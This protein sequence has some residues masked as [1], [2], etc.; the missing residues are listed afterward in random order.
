MRIR[1]HWGT[2]VALVYS[3]FALG[4]LGFVAFAMG[5][6]PTLVSPQYYG[7][8]LAHDQRMAAAANARTLGPAPDVRL[9]TDGTEMVLQLP[10]SHAASARGTLT[11]Y[12]AS[13]AGADRVVAL[14]LAPDG[15]QRVSLDGLAGGRWRVQV[16][17]TVDG[18]PYYYERPFDKPTSADADQGRPVVASPNG[19]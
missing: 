17:W 3:A 1:L 2:G 6:P 14:S 8:A 12:R 13:D 4:T 9:T 10:A 11:L 5:R 16:E 18:R 15:R 19:L 7:R